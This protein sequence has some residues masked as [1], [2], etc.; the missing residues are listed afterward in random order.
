MRAYVLGSMMLWSALFVTWYVL[1]LYTANNELEEIGT[2]VAGVAVMS[3]SRCGV[4]LAALL[5]MGDK[6]LKAGGPEVPPE[7][8]KNIEYCISS[9]TVSRDTLM[10]TQL[11]RFFPA[12]K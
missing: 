5:A 12:E 8:R 4:E 11:I 2:R 7:L 1:T 10:N 9:D 6:L 3:A